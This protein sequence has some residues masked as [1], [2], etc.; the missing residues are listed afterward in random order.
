M[1]SNQYKSLSIQ[2]AQRD[3]RE[4]FIGGFA[5]QLVAGILWLISAGVATWS[6]QALALGVL[7]LG[8][9]FIFPLTQ[10]VLRLMGRRGSLARGHPMND[11]ARQ[12]AFTLPL[13]FPVVLAL[14]IYR[15]D[16]FYPAFMVVLGAHYLPF[17]FLYGM[18]QFS[19]LCSV[20]VGAG[21]G[22]A[23]VT[24]P[25]SFGGWFTGVVLLVFAFV[26]RAVARKKG[27]QTERQLEFLAHQR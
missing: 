22:L 2:E 18:W 6:S 20:L 11:L 24:L 8:G 17:V 16:W 12:I 27:I 10:L 25:Y 14:S 9:S 26:G 19:V 13:S 3:V 4:T 15:P 1:T 21:V 5:G 23:Y 7:M